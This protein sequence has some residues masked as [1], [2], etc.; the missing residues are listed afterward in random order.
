MARWTSVC[1]LD[2]RGLQRRHVLWYAFVPRAVRCALAAG[3]CLCV[4][5]HQKLPIIAACSHELQALHDNICLS[6]HTT[7][8]SA[9]LGCRP[10]LS[11]LQRQR[12]PQ[13][14]GVQGSQNAPCCSLSRRRCC[15]G[16]SAVLCLGHSKI[17]CWLSLWYS[18]PSLRPANT[19]RRSRTTSATSL[20]SSAPPL[21]S[22][23]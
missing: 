1:S 4:S 11:R 8:H 16:I 20:S 2:G 18:R 5:L 9:C 19:L 15:W 7:Y 13:R 21:L 17:P 3:V 6:R 22:A 14:C 12:C 23:C 10:R